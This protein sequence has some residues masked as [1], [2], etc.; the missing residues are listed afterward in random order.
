MSFSRAPVKRFNENVGCAPPP[1]TYEVKIGEPKGPA[2]FHKSERFRP[3][4]PV[5]AVTPQ[6]P[7]KLVPMSPVRRT[8]SADGLAD[9]LS[10]RKEKSSITMQMKQQKL[11]EKE[12]RSLLTQR[13]E[14][15]RRL[16][17][18]EEELRKVEA[19]LLSAVR[20]KTGLS[21][22]VTSLER[23]LAE[24]KKANEFL[25]NKVSADTTKKRI[26]SLTMELMEARN[27]LD[28]KD[29]EVSFLQINTEGQVKVLETDLEA[30]RATLSALMERNR[31]LEDLHQATKAQ[32]EELENEID[33]L[34]GLIQE[35]REETKALQGYLDTANDQ[36]QDLRMNLREKTEMEQSLTASQQEKMDNLENKLVR[37][38][39]ELESSQNALRQQ[40]E[41]SKVRQR[42][43]QASQ[44]ALGQMEGEMKRAKQEA[45]DSQ[46]VARQQG[47]ELS[48]LR[49]VLRRTEAELDERV[50][51]LGERCL[52]LEDE[53]GRTQEEGL[54]R[55]QELKAE[56]SSLQESMRSEEEA[57]RQHQ[58][59]HTALTEELE[60]EKERA[61][62][63]A[64]T[65]AR[66]REE[67]GLEQRQLEDEL[68][69]ALGELSA[70]EEQEQRREEEE[71]GRGEALHTLRQEKAHLERE[72]GEARAQ[73]IRMNSETEASEETRGA[74]LRGLQ[75]ELVRS[76]SK[77]GELATEL[78]STKQ[79]LK[80]A[81]DRG[82]ELGE[83]ME[84]AAR[85]M[86]DEM[87]GLAR[88]KE[89]EVQR[90]RGEM[91][92]R[93]EALLSSQQTQE[94]AREEFARMLLDVQTRLA[95]RE[96]EVETAK[97]AHAS[98]AARL[99][100]EQRDREEAQRK[101]GQREKE[102]AL[103]KSAREE[104]AQSRLQRAEEE[105][106]EA[107]KRLG[108]ERD[109]KEEARSLLKRERGER[110][111]SRQGRAEEV[112]ALRR[113]VEEME[114]ERGSLQTR[115]DQERE[116]L[117]KRVEEVE[118]DKENLQNQVEEIQQD[119]ESL[120]RRVEEGEQGMRVLRE[121]VEVTVQEK[122]TLQWEMEEQRRE[123]QTLL[124]Q[125]Q[126]KSSS[127]SET[128]HWKRLY[129]ELFAKVKPFQEQLNGFA[130]ERDALLSE[131]G[132]TQEEMT[133][134]ADAYA[135]L[136]GHQNQRQKIRHVV[137][138]KDDNIAL[139]QELSKL[140]AQV[141]R[142]KKDMEQLKADQA[143]HR[144]DP[145]KAFQHA[146]KENQQPPGPAA[147]ALRQG[148][149]L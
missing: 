126:E 32:N 110:R 141:S 61:S 22:S 49:E 138:L 65:L 73:L 2:S 103:E 3:A 94:K 14:Q 80:S 4:K 105:V 107:L 92:A 102:E 145:S 17:S 29:K 23:Q 20:E 28:V 87:E 71:R 66:A 33:K 104:E 62:V 55:V 123:I 121:Q 45:L 129:E 42:D 51:H 75:E 1:G 113:R 30:A 146:S 90:L 78:Q 21:A 60:K 74:A 19:K 130:A 53:R 127:D 18:L 128:E 101:L 143:P 41:E 63:L 35:L 34:H 26:N 98:L 82:R 142:Q 97:E 100:E 149:R 144:F 91:E 58:L 50:A 77:I 89:E 57:L 8:M 93:D 84:G 136:L 36:I 95:Q 27:K 135:R 7:S 117:T 83:E 147:A 96:K 39:L 12:I 133:R 25:K 148:N 106:G 114:E 44:D 48:R 137:K 16:Q 13:G 99:Q 52:F 139:K 76:L 134:L 11:L 5:S 116:N 86:K 69:E 31:D 56:L 70:L 10:A 81:E 15:D 120:R 43:L 125:S 47:A 72:L 40:E 131:N 122:V 111:D 6:S 9:V 115:M 132:V 124:A 68:E 67:M 59:S 118:Q 79:A 38:T 109:E 108:Q 46:D 119:E 88:T 140:R 85:Q 112:G 37:F 24:M 64:S 54:K